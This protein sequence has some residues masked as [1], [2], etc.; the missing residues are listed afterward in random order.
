[1]DTIGKYRE[2][3]FSQ[4]RQMVID[5][6]ELGFSKHHVCAFLELDV[7]KARRLLSIHK[8]NK[9]Q[10]LSF[11]GW[12]AKCIGQAVSE[13]PHVHAIRRGRHNSVIFEDVDIL[14]TIQKEINGEEIPLPYVVR[15]VNEK[16]IEQITSEIRS[17]QSQPTESGTIMI[18]DKPWFANFY[19]HLPK[20]IRTTFARLMAR[21][22]FFVKKYTGTIGISAVGMMGN[23]KGWAI[24][25]S[26]QP[27]YF[28]LGGIVEKPGVVEKQI[29][30]REFLHLSFVF[31][32]DVVD[33]TPIARF[34]SCL[35]SLVE[36]G[37]GLST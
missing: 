21:D 1:M 32:H 9:G 33:G 19:L 23:F 25:V 22:P 16:S 28:A 31:D 35:T 27:L 34:V 18:G 29:A 15:K 8:D 20:I 4:S 7:T 17:A 5:V 14:I 30:I 13:H 24:P 10:S 37:F 36:G 2:E 12:M 3:F 11:T 6:V 26:P